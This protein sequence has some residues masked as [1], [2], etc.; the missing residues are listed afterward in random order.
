MCVL[1]MPA[2]V[3][4]QCMYRVCT[5]V[6]TYRC[7]WSIHVHVDYIQT[8]CCIEVGDRLSIC[9]NTEGSETRQ[10]ANAFDLA[11]KCEIVHNII[12]LF[13]TC[14]CILLIKRKYYVPTLMHTSTY[15]TQCGCLDITMPL[16]VRKHGRPKGHEVTVIGLPAI[17][18]NKGAVVVVVVAVI[19]QQAKRSW[20]HL[21]NYTLL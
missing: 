8:F 12:I 11:G 4:V 2:R 21:S 7:R 19:Q 17:K 6:C 3:C 13:H 18:P 20:C 1:C 16:I 14:T 15:I 10:N 5:G 9:H